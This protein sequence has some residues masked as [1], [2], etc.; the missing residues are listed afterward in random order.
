[1]APMHERRHE[2]AQLVAQDLSSSS[3]S[4]SLSSLLLAAYSSAAAASDASDATSASWALYTSSSSES[5]VDSVQSAFILA[6][7]QLA[8][9]LPPS[10]ALQAMRHLDMALMLNAPYE[11]LEDILHKV[12]PLAQALHKNSLAPCPP[13]FQA[14]TSS[15]TSSSYPPLLT[16]SAPPPQASFKKEYYNPGK[17]LLLP[18]HA[19]DWPAVQRWS[20]LAYLDAALGH[21]TVPL[22]MGTFPAT[23]REETL[24]FGEF[25]R[26]HLAVE[27][28]SSSPAYL[29]QHALL[30]QVPAL[31][32]DVGTPPY[33]DELSS[34]ETRVLC[35]IG[36]AH[37]VTPLHY[38]SYDT[39]FVQ[40][41]GT[42]RFTLFDKTETPRLYRTRRESTRAN[43][44]TTNFSAVDVD[45]PD[46]D[47]YPLFAEASGVTVTLE[48]G[49]VLYIPSNVWHHVRALT[50]SASI[51]FAF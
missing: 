39:M 17:P 46:L 25:A 8:S 50:P 40:V 7:L 33:V 16:P 47:K 41:V 14:T 24:R 26:N 51:S 23:F 3:S 38:D 5:S 15:T 19:L 13:W 4:S 2:L 22:E 35:W 9:L 48:P 10:D 27:Q 11:L 45:A 32:D 31:A 29:A 20:N 49:D 28:S 6:S 12:E 36:T 34:E 37:T 43:A 21:R 44:S 18:K 42:K 1:M 30:E